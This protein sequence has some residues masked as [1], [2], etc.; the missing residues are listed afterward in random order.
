[1]INV[2]QLL[3]MTKGGMGPDEMAEL[4]GSMGMAAKFDPVEPARKTAEFQGLWDSASLP[5]SSVM[6]LE[7]RMKTGETF[8][9]LLVLNQPGKLV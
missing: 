6:R 2:L 9:G 4:L 5:Q 8:T 7:I 3:K 1:M